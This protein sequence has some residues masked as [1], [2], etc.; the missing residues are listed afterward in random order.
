M[1]KQQPDEPLTVKPSRGDYSPIDVERVDR[2]INES[3][4]KKIVE[5][6]GRHPDMALRILRSWADANHR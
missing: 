1:N 3:L 2:R 6:I 4:R 5:L